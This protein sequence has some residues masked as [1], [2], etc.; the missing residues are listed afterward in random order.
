MSE[1]GHVMW[2]G[3]FAAPMDPRLDRLNRSL[4]VDRR[5]W[6]EDLETNRAWVHA[7]EG[8]GVLTAAERAE[9]SRGLDAVERQ[10]AAGAAA[11]AEDEDIHSLVERLLGLVVG[12]LAGKLH[13]GRSRNDQMGTDLRLWTMGAL[14]RL[15]AALAALGRVLVERAEAGLD[16]LMPAYT[17]T[18]RAQPVRAAH[19][20]LAHAWPLARDRGRVAD[21]RGRTAQLPLG[22]GAIAG[23]GFA[24][25]RRDLAARLGF[26]AVAPN[27]LDA[28]GDRDF[29]LEAAFV[30]ALAATHASRLA[31]DL[32]LFSTAEFGF[33]VLPESF[34]TGSSLMPQKRNPDA[35][36]LARGA[37]G[38]VIGRLVGM[39]VTLKGLPTGY[40]K[41]LQENNAALFEVFDRVTSVVEMLEG[42]VAGLGFV[43]ERMAAALDAGTRATDLADLLVQAGLPFRQAHGLVG[44]LVRRAEELGVPLDAVPAGEVA[45]LDANLAAPLAALGGAEAAV[46]RRGVEGGTAR[47]A[48]LAQL[49]E[50]RAAFAP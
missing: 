44:R 47:A 34:T 25:D 38:Q 45:A 36:E 29:A 33:V 17:H 4:P 28:V 46:E 40:Q 23:S 22:A 8:V 50:A 31:E 13:T 37:A 3:R 18:Q 39:L 35:L 20:V 24:V 42:V 30:A 14:D 19:W 1:D 21:A 32:I 49:A 5:L 27:S 7:L 41:D 10:L 26:A 11:G 6:R 43:P 2:G 15:D 48:V 12:P 9:L 16:V